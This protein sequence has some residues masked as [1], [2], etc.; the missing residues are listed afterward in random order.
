M[1][2]IK[3][4]ICRLVLFI[5]VHLK[6]GSMYE[7][8][9]SWSHDGLHAVLYTKL[10]FIAKDRDRRPFVVC[11]PKKKV[12]NRSCPG[13]QKN[14]LCAV[15]TPFLLVANRTEQQ[16]PLQLRPC[17]KSKKHHTHMVGIARIVS[18]LCRR[19][20]LHSPACVR[21]RCLLP[22][23][24]YFQSKRARADDPGGGLLKSWCRF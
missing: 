1:L 13:V 10:K 4:F 7:P 8:Q 11:L 2:I 17:P 19:Q 16:R 18:V 23:L 6:R 24:R 9:G 22:Q 15:L 3:D 5:V 14:L 21:L 20:A 12:L